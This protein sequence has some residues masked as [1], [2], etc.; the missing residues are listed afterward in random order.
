MYQNQSSSITGEENLLKMQ[1][2]IYAEKR[3]RD[4]DGLRRAQDKIHSNDM[5]IDCDTSGWN[6]FMFAYI[7]VSINGK[8]LHE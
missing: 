5:N 4:S 2:R 6:Y 3:E 1:F 8:I 7:S